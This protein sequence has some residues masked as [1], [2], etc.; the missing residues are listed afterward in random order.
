MDNYFT[1]TR[2]NVLAL[3][4]N[5]KFELMRHDVTFPTATFSCKDYG[6]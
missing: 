3:L 5:Q 2:D 1:G 4:D 6:G